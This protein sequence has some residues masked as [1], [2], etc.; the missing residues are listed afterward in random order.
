MNHE[1]KRREELF[2]DPEEIVTFAQAFYATE[3]PND[4][5]R[6]CPP[7]AALRESARSGALPDGQLRSHLFNC[8]ECFRSFRSARMSRHTQAAPA[9]RWLRR[10]VLVSAKL[11]SPWLP[12]TV[13]ACCLLFLGL[14]A[15]T[16]LRHASRGSAAVAVNYSRQEANPATVSGGAETLITPVES[17]SES[18]R[19]GQAHPAL[20]APPRAHKVSPRNPRTQPPL[21]VVYIDLKEDNLLR[22]DDSAG[23]A[24]RVITLSP[25]RQRLRLRMPQGSAAGW[26]TVRVV[27]AYGKTLLTTSAR[28][29]GRTLRVEMDLRGL[30]A[31][32]YR[33]CLSR[34]G[35]APDCYLMSVGPN[36]PRP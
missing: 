17:G 9:R 13:G 33:L 3:F 4:A 22:G 7:P 15:L 35:E 32:T 14:I 24:R 2:A 8:S 21:P 34:E 12:V 26:Y 18:G 23:P 20:E 11:R 5:W 28:S 10:L 27:D 29:N 16:L 1:H 6:G 36:P 31:K 19:R 30:T 25:E